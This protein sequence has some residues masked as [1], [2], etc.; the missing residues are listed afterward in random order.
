[1]GGSEWKECVQER[2]GKGGIYRLDVLEGVS[3]SR[4]SVQQ[5]FK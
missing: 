5:T 1:M 4:Y 3:R 2:G